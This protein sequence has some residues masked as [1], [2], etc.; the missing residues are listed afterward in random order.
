MEG[1]TP[2]IIAYLITGLA[3]FFGAGLAAFINHLIS[4]HSLK[5]N[6]VVEARKQWIEEL[7]KEVTDFVNTTLR[8]TPSMYIKGADF[9]QKH[10]AEIEAKKCIILLRLTPDSQRS[11]RE[12]SWADKH[13]ELKESVEHST[14]VALEVMNNR[15][16]YG[17][18]KKAL[19]ETQDISR[20]ILYHTWRQIRREIEEDTK[21][22]KQIIRK[23]YPELSDYLETFI[24][25]A[26]FGL[27]TTFIIIFIIISLLFLP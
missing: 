9:K 5:A 16:T 26:F 19:T 27:T 10:S 12:N 25:G 4:R 15:L 8:T 7:R 21:I 17:D 23:V 11:G 22:H 3:A 14:Y 6:I 24:F 13:S 18:L 1:Q 2:N 20:N